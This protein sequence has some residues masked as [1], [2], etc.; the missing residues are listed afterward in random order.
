MSHKTVL[1]RALKAQKTK[2]A[3]NAS[4]TIS[5]LTP[6]ANP[7]LSDEELQSYIDLL[8]EA[9]KTD[10][11]SKLERLMNDSADITHKILVGK[12]KNYHQ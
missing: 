4:Q 3:A 12:Y 2:Q 6:S 11:T 9:S 10:P 5:P 1:E 8:L 7:K